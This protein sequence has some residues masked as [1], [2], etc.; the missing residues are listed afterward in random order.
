MSF[1][2]AP[3][4]YLALVGAMI[5]DLGAAQNVADLQV[6]PPSV[7]IKVGERTGLLATAFD[8]AGNVIPTARITW[9]SNNVKVAR[10]DNN[11]TVV[12][13]S[14]G[15]A[16]IQ[17]TAG[18]R[19]G[20]VVVQV[21]GTAA[22]A[23]PAASPGQPAP[24]VAA[25]AAA[26]GND[27]YAGQPAGVGAPAALRIDPP[28]IYLLPSENMRVF[29][30]ALRED[31]SPAAPVQ[32]TWKS[33]KEDVA[34][35]DAN[36][37]V[38]GLAAG[39]GTVLMTGP[40]GL[41]ATAPVIVDQA[42]FSILEG[43]SVT[44][45]PGDLDTMHV[46]VRSQGNR[47]VSALASLQ[48]TSSDQ[49]VAQV[50]LTGVVKAVGSGKA[51]LTA[52]GLR[53]QKSIDILVHRAVEALAVR[54]KA[55]ADVPVPL[56]AVVRFF[57]QPLAADN[58]PVPEAKIRWVLADTTIASFDTTT[59]AL[60]GRKIGRTQLTARGPGA[61]PATATWNVNVIAGAVKLAAVRLGLVQGGR[62][63]LK[64]SFADDSGTILGPA[65]GLSWSSDAPAVATVGEDGT[66]SGVAYGRARITA[67][68]PGGKTASAVVFV[69][70]ELVVASTRGGKPQLYWVDRQNLADLHRVTAP[71]D[72][73]VAGDPAF[74]PDG[75][76]IAFVSTR[77]GNPD[78]Y[79][80][81]ADGSSPLRLTTDPQADGH[82][83]FSADGNTVFFHSQRTGK[84]QIYSVGIDGSG[85]KVLTTDSVSQTPAVSPDGRT[86]AYVSFRNKSYDVWLMSPDGSNQRA[87]TRTAAPMQEVE[88]RFLRDG[89]L[90]YV[91]ERREANK[92][93]RQV[94]KADL[95]TGTTTPVTG[96]EQWISSFAASPAGD[97]LALVVP[98]DPDNKKNPM[99]RIFLQPVSGG[100]PVQIP[101]T[102]AEQT[103]APAFLP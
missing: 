44:L 60:T 4:I 48:W 64:A 28:T 92:T 7:T 30:R 17:A 34:S 32:V 33:L 57:A 23:E 6:A 97:V 79:V 19:K 96:T 27:A 100:T 58:N 75:S 66:V 46:I 71:Q 98:G 77:D 20:S 1:R 25:P 53:Q 13:V 67:T 91:Q 72:T 11:G 90:L 3:I 37:N 78:I 16:L 54:P 47:L 69:G 24:V 29:P 8:R 43:T 83:V 85:L 55:S 35:V 93:V 51:T 9:S 22:P 2:R 68:A 52:A 31:G 42:E 99:A 38:V 40:G 70:A 74:S 61:Q 39:Q 59:G 15:T 49:S 65:T 63:T 84:S 101:T 88:P 86:V 103:L 45:S 10:V 12:G 56:T 26:A 50:S 87:F 80:M 94:I 5:P 82:P 81:D 14:G 73:A 89:S 41:T 76:R 102:G 62:T 21:T 18:Q 95:A 36:G